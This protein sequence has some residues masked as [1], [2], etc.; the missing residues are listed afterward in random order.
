[1][2]L[3]EIQ[4]LMRVNCPNVGGGRVLCGWGLTNMTQWRV[5]GS[6]GQWAGGVTH[7]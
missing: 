6:W 7:L 5:R 4:T 2:G 1:M 3:S